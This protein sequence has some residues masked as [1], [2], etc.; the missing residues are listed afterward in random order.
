VK[1][2]QTLKA[3]FNWWDFEENLTFND[4]ITQFL[5]YAHF[6]PSIVVL[7]FTILY[8]RPK[9]F[10]HQEEILV[11]KLVIAIIIICVF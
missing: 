9:D 7:Y 8:P 5:Q 11:L 2:I 10:T 1:I 4:Q 3:N 6:I